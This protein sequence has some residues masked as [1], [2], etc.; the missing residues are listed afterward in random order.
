M[1]DRC[2]SVAPIVS[3]SFDRKV[4]R[5][6]YKLNS[7]LEPKPRETK[8]ASEL[9]MYLGLGPVHLIQPNNVSGAVRRKG[10]IK[11]WFK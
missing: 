4:S 5:K 9:F 2:A 11:R 1:S 10:L 7:Y 8:G 6:H 3:C